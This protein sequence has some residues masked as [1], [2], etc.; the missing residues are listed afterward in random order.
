VSKQ[1]KNRGSPRGKSSES[2]AKDVIDLDEIIEHSFGK[3]RLRNTR[4]TEAQAWFRV[5]INAVTAK[6]VLRKNAELEDI[7]IRITRLEEAKK[8]EPR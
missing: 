7:E 6:E 3:T 2:R 4:N 1:G 5:I 8:N